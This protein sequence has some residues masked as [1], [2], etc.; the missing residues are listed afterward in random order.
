MSVNQFA[1][2]EGQRRA[3]AV[4][5]FLF[6]RLAEKVLAGHDI[7]ELAADLVELQTEIKCSDPQSMNNMKAE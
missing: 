2:Q 3:A 7:S 6:E 1:H 4:R 5:D